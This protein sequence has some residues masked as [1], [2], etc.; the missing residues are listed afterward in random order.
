[1]A[2]PASDAGGPCYTCNVRVSSSL[3]LHYKSPFHAHNVRLRNDDLPPLSWSEF[4]VITA[5]A[6]QRQAAAILAAQ[7]VIFVCDACGKTFATEGPFD[8]H[9]KSK[10]HISQIKE[11][12][13]L[14]RQEEAAGGV[15]LSVAAEAPATMAKVGRASPVDETKKR[16]VDNEDDNEDSCDDTD[17]ESSALVVSACSCLFCFADH[18]DFERYVLWTC[19]SIIYL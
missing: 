19:T 15:L 9:C 11:I 2:K 5:E 3:M 1:M 16:A 6:G 12:L 18:P 4:S 7:S 17:D 8:A 13:A 10:R 14:R